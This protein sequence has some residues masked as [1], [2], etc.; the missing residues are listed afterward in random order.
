MQPSPTTW[1]PSSFNPTLTI[2][3]F[4][5]IVVLN[6]LPA[7]AYLAIVLS[8][9]GADVHHLDRISA[10]D[11]LR[12]QFVTYIPLGLYLIWIV[13]A[14][15]LRSLRE[16][17]VRR[18]TPREVA[19]GLAGTAAMVLAIDV[20]GGIIAALT[21]R[22]DTEQAVALLKELHSPGDLALFVVIAAVLAPMIEELTFRVFLFNA[23]SRY[24]SFPV[25]AAC[26]SIVFGIFH[27]AAPAQ[28]VTV[29]IPLALGGLVLCWIYG[30]TRCY[31]SNVITHAAFNGSSVALLFLFPNS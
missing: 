24:A 3:A 28:L 4:V 11:L 9:R 14:L 5:G 23:V 31:W 17:G 20:A 19:I 8:V 27:A 12:A 2:L 1:E 21:H 29:S 25:A 22:H 30:T 26:S 10:H 15:S 18:P 16:L 7:A 13:P 6:V